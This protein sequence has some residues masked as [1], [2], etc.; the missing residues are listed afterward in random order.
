MWAIP[1]LAL[2]RGCVKRAA[3]SLSITAWLVSCRSAVQPSFLGAAW[4]HR[5]TLCAVAHCWI[6]TLTIQPRPA[7]RLQPMAGNHRH[8]FFLLPQPYEKSISARFQ[9]G[10]IALRSA[11]DDSGGAYQILGRASTD[12]I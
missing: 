2:R 5:V 1:Y 7:K 8:P 10:D 12:I 11:A 6:D 3:T 4:N 9:T